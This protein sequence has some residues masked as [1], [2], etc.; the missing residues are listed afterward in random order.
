MNEEL[1]LTYVNS[2]IGRFAFNPRLLSWD[3][4]EYHVMNSVREVLKDF[5]VDNV[6][7]PGGCTPHIQAPD[8]SWNKPFKAHVTD[9]YD[10]WLCSGIHEYT[11]SGNM[12]APPSRKIVEW[13]LD[14]W[15]NLSKEL[16]RKS[17]K[18][19]ALNLSIDG[20]EDELIHCFKE[21]TASSSGAERQ[22]EALQVIYDESTKG[23]PFSK[24]TDLMRMKN[25][26]I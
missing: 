17:F 6:I 13:I 2:I 25:V 3:S 18:S 16:I 22:T 4:F 7:V 26:T 8:V 20:S 19:C 5:N 1:T 21:N 15:S 9:E 14:S 10:K 11:K 12:K 24:P 23:N